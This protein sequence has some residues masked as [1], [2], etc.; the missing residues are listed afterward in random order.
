MTRFGLRHRRRP[1]LPGLTGIARVDR[2]I[3]TLLPRLQPGDIAVLDHVDLD[4]AT[5]DA[6]VAAGVAAV[7]NASPSISGRYPNLGP[8]ILVDAG[9]MVIDEVGAAALHRIKDGSEVRLHEARVY[10]GERC[11]AEG[12]E[13]TPE[14]VAEALIQAQAGIAH[15]LEAFAANTVEFLHREYDL[16]LGGEGL[17]EIGVDLDGRPVVVVAG[18]YDHK[19]ELAGLKRYI[20]EHRPVLIGVGGGADAL[21]A[22][23]YQPDV[24]VGDPTGI[25]RQALSCDTIVV[26]ALA[27]GHAPGLD[28]AQDLG[29]RAVTV[30]TSANP[31]DVALLL[32]HHGGASLIVAVGLTATLAEFLD[33]GRS[34]S[35]ASTF[36]TRLR[37]GSTLVDGAVVAQLYRGSVPTSA[38]VLLAAA[39][40]FAGIAA[41]LVSAAGE[42]AL[43]WLADIGQNLVSGGAEEGQ[44]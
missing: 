31:E 40:L 13:Q 42:A 41:L 37:L 8:G 11:L 28:H 33:R 5:A 15:Q 25:S 27:E 39:A 35:N 36:L 22:A 44:P 32:A 18:G 38:V 12:V 17:P 29:V 26:P 2:R 19:V 16:L 23:G 34:G 30:T 3:D 43:A 6:L 21:A 7:V 14:S 24:V 20:S 10:A 9:V 1:E 4:R